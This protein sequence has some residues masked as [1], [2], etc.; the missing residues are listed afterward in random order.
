MFAGDAA[1]WTILAQP[2]QTNVKPVQGQVPGVNQ[3]GRHPSPQNR[4]SNLVAFKMASLRR[5]HS[6]VIEYLGVNP[7]KAPPWGRHGPA[8]PQTGAWITG[9]TAAFIAP[10]AGHT[11]AVNN[12]KQYV[13]WTYC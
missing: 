5:G 1:L 3:S 6:E 4:G 12:L 7:E 9:E 10:W 8:G 2:R 13:G 11:C